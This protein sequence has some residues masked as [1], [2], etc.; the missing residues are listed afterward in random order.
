MIVLTGLGATF[1]PGTTPAPLLTQKLFSQTLLTTPGVTQPTAPAPAPTPVFVRD[2]APPALPAPSGVD[3]AA[4]AQAAADL[5]AQAQAAADA[6]AA[7]AALAAQHGS[8]ADQ[9]AANAEAQ[10]QQAIADVAAGI[11]QTAIDTFTTQQP[12]QGTAPSPGMTVTP[13][14]PAYPEVYATGS[15]YGI[16]K[17]SK[18]TWLM[19]GAGVV[20]VGLLVALLRR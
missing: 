17:Y 15:A 1:N 18:K 10:Q 12:D 8:T 4:Q 14:Q 5:A 2:A 11:A 20:G 19:I 7:V 3:L 9:V 16:P 13:T 6:A